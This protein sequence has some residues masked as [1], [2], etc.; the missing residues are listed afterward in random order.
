MTSSGCSPGGRAVPAAGGGAPRVR[1]RPARSVRTGHWRSGAGHRG[2]TTGGTDPFGLPHPAD[3]RRPT[4]ITG[5][6]RDGAAGSR[7]HVVRTGPATDGG[8]PGGGRRRPRRHDPEPVAVRLPTVSSRPCAGRT[9]PVP[10]PPRLFR[11][12]TGPGWGPWPKAS[13]RPWSGRARAGCLRDGGPPPPRIPRAASA[14][15][16]PTRCRYGR[17]PGLH[18]G[19]GRPAAARPNASSTY[20]RTRGGRAAPTPARGPAQAARADHAGR[21][22]PTTT[23]VGDYLS[24]GERPGQRRRC[25]AAVAGRCALL[26]R[27]GRRTTRW[28]RS[29]A[30]TGARSPRPGRDEA[31]RRSDQSTSSC[32][33][34]RPNPSMRHAGLPAR[35][36]GRGAASTPAAALDLHFYQRYR[37]RDRVVGSG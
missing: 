25:L 3:E 30:R 34:S 23:C 31:R 20:R 15:D 4:L 13:P 5:R 19:V 21:R 10:E 36:L 37:G 11:R 29:S 14:P 33:G 26:R 28:T 8:C 2:P 35:A 24:R 6:E 27:T 1:P 18:G 17:A 22:G 7:R 9:T 32:T 12:A 16:R